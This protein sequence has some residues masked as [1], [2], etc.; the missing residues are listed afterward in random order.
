[1]YIPR[2]ICYFERRRDQRSGTHKQEKK[3]AW[4][5][6]KNIEGTPYVKAEECQT[7]EMMSLKHEHKKEAKKSTYQKT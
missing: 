5:E 7:R 1:M 2:G 4:R 6:K 3:R